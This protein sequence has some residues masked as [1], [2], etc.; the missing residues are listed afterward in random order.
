M[1]WGSKQVAISLHAESVQSVCT[2]NAAA[3]KRDV[4]QESLNLR[5]SNL[6]ESAP[7]APTLDDPYT[8]EKLSVAGYDSAGGP[9]S[10]LNIVLS[11]H[12]G[13][14]KAPDTLTSGTIGGEAW[15]VDPLTKYSEADMEAHIR[16][17]TSRGLVGIIGTAASP[18]RLAPSSGSFLANQ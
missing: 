2:R 3:G 5:A 17:D 9:S 12:L 10:E 1:L 6:T 8:R 16:E 13:A 18:S 14:R 11:D 15:E 7:L 4:K